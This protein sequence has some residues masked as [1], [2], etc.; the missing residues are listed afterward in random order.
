MLM[1]S[2]KHTTLNCFTVYGSQ[3]FNIERQ[4]PLVHPGGSARDLVA[5]VVEDQIH[6]QLRACGWAW[7]STLPSALLDAHNE[8]LCNFLLQ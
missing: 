2:Y 3:W 5:D 1:N 4:I 7:L 6:V 8:R